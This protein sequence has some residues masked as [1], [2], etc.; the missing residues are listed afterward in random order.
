ML[1][2]DVAETLE[3]GLLVIVL[4]LLRA[5]EPGETQD[6]IMTPSRSSVVA[7]TTRE[8][9]IQRTGL[10]DAIRGANTLR[11]EWQKRGLQG[12]AR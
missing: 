1:A 8:P 2:L 6:R 12:D 9:G 4:S 10:E 7:A 11:R 3:V 5:F